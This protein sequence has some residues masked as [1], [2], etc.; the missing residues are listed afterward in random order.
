MIKPATNDSQCGSFMLP[1]QCHHILYEVDGPET[2]AL[3]L[4]PSGVKVVLVELQ[5][6]RLA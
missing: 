6:N 5:D 4:Y 1:E 3:S 2:C